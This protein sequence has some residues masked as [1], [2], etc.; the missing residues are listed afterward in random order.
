MLPSEAREVIKLLEYLSRGTTS[1]Y[2]MKSI[3]V[4]TQHY[5]KYCRLDDEIVKKRVVIVEK[6][7]SNMLKSERKIIN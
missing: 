1:L 4:A 7:L 6:R 3:C 2:Q 5:L